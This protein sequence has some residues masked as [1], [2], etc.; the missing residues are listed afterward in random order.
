MN[1]M[2]KINKNVQY[3]IWLSIKIKLLWNL[4]VVIFITHNVYL[5]GSNKIA[6][7]LCVK[8]KLNDSNYNDKK[9]IYY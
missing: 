1:K 8:N 2:N 5:Y 4:I 9:N 3:V 6:D 7:A